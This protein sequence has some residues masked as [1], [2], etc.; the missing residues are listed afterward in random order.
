MPQ[1][2]TIAR[3]NDLGRPGLWRA[4]L[5]TD[6]PTDL[7]LANLAASLDAQHQRTSAR[8]KQARIARWRTRM[9]AKDGGRT[10]VG[11]WPTLADAGQTVA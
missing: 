7:Q 4:V 6:L 9:R 3:R 5:A 10:V 8:D 2:S 11:R 1:A